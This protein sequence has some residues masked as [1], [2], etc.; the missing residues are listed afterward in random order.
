[1]TQWDKV[2]EGEL[3]MHVIDVGYGDATLFLYKE[4]GR[5]YSVLLD[6][7]MP[8]EA[9]CE[10]GLYGKTRLDIFHAY[11]LRVPAI[12]TNRNGYADRFLAETKKDGSRALR[13]LEKI[14]M[15]KGEQIDHVINS[16]P[17]VDHIGGLPAVLMA[18]PA[19]FI[20]LWSKSIYATSGY[21]LF[22][23][24][25]STDTKTPD[26]HIKVTP[27]S[28]DNPVRQIYLPEETLTARIGDECHISGGD[29]AVSMRDRRGRVVP[30]PLRRSS[31]IMPD[32]DVTIL[33]TTPMA[34]NVIAPGGED[35][36]QGQSFRLGERGPV[37]TQLADT[38]V[39]YRESLREKVSNAPNAFINNQSLVYRIDYADRRIM[40][41]G[42][43][44]RKGI[45]N[46]LDVWGEDLHADIYKVTHHGHENRDGIRGLHAGAY[47]LI[48]AVNPSISVCSCGRSDTHNLNPLVVRDLRGSDLYVTGFRLESRSRGTIIFRISDQGRITANCRPSFPAHRRKK[49]P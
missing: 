30:V 7:G 47:E 44:Q 22:R 14:G 49:S 11:A 46:L 15:P 10:T 28:H 26:T 39:S 1:M 17:H 16:H 34:D 2:Q 25:L 42:D 19:R 5:M 40:M 6:G 41:A 8:T 20:H 18:H 21:T 45:Q 38:R 13:Y 24:Y 3:Q 36:F 27:V 9:A 48:K 31:F 4:D 32:Y 37:F 23:R 29:C 35:N 12:F 33:P 43:L